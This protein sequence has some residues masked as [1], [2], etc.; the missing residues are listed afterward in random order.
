M[1]GG[2]QE[3][4]ILSA[5]M[6][7]QGVALGSPM[8]VAFVR[9]AGTTGDHRR[10]APHSVVMGS[11]SSLASS[12]FTP[13]LRSLKATGFQ[14]RTVIF[15][16][17]MRPPDIEVISGLADEVIELDDRYPPLAPP[18]VVRA[19]G[20]VKAQR[21]V[22]RFY[23]GVYRATA[24]GLRA[25]PGS[26]VA[27][28]LE[29]RLQGIQALRYRHYLEYLASAPA[30]EQVMISDLRDVVFQRN[31]FENEALELEV[32]LE[33][34]HVRTGTPGF[35]STWLQD[36]YGDEGVRALGDQVISCSG[37]TLGRREGM[38][39]Y[40]RTM[41]REV[42]RHSFPLG[43]HDQAIHNWLLYTGQLPGATAVANGR[44]RVQTMGAQP[45]IYLASDGMVV[46]PDGTVP[47]VLHQ[48]D[49]HRALTERFLSAYGD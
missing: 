22:R 32:F 44:G 36:L 29:F 9:R 49:R 17:D 6:P 31:P 37:V 16:T 42:R 18:L 14:G 47:A 38:L 19:L 43:P 48:Y 23:P 45:E 1:H 15:V 10:M 26:E 34:P 46:N 2:G 11:A 39:T 12:H 41:D 8:Q 3:T 7:A 24:K 40:L 13:F 30:I 28:D 27:L 21:G 35:N 25:A 4:T 33:E 5:Q 20:R